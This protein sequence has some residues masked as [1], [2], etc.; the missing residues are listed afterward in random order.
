[1]GLN[2]SEIIRI[3]KLT[4]V[5]Q[6]A[7]TAPVKKPDVKPAPVAPVVDTFSSNPS[8]DHWESEILRAK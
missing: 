8:L 3:A 7:A 4:I 6:P 2:M 5:A 1:M